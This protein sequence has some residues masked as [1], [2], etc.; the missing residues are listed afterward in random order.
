MFISRHVRITRTAI[1]PRLAIRILPNTDS[2]CLVFLTQPVVVLI[3]TASR[4]GEATHPFAQ[5]QLG[6][7][8]A[9]LRRPL[10]GKG[11]KPVA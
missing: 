8:T 4:P 6:W 3:I 11:D 5:G 9:G 2:P 7:D 1:S 10:E